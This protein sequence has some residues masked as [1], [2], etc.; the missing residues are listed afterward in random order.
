MKGK[1]L[2][3]DDDQQIL[4][5]LVLLLKYDFKK[6]DT[7]SNPNLILNKVTEEKYDLILL[8]MNFKASVSTGNEGLFWLQKILDEDS[9]S[10]VIM[11]TAYGDVN[12]AVKAMKM[13]AIDFIQKPW[14]SEKLITNLKTALQLQHSKKKLKELE[15][16]N[17]A[18][19]ENLNRFYPEFIG[20]SKAIKKI[21]TIIGKV[22]GTD[23]NVLILGENGTGKDLV[24]REIHRQSKRSEKPFVNVDLASVSPTLFES[25]LFGHTKGAFTDAKE[26]RPGRF[27]TASEGTL[28]LDEIGNLPLSLQSKILTILENREV[29]R[30]GSNE[31][32][33][34][35]I[36][37][38]TATNSDLIKMVDDHL[39]REDLLYRINT[40]C[41]EMPPL[42]ERGDD[43][44]LL[45]EFFLTRFKGK[46]Q[47]PGLKIGQKAI[48]KL[49][50]YPWPGNVRELQHTI[51]NTVIL[52]D[53]EVLTPGDFNLQTFRS[54]DAESLNLEVVERSTIEKAL[55][56]NRG[57]YSKTAEE[58]GISRTTLY[59]KI[60]KYGLQ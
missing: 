38:I 57:K 22:S 31:K 29:I 17:L 59:H 51:E 19:K 54:W 28:F 9:E 2:I 52:C 40:V 41:I 21:F 50:H 33:T 4:E 5:S 16:D 56:K 15:K 45:T 13:G 7:L 30:L 23:A 8:D 12:L 60:K 36:R 48:E 1:L 3:I 25:E 53:K 35:D 46:Y 24:A 43:I 26:D 55:N 47:K 27:E 11:I 39:F 10:A 44:I 20:E 58:L 34:V 37:L 32:K 18:L 42:R 14:S 6:I 49:Q